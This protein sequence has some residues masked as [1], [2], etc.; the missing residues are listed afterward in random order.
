MVR[1]AASVHGHGARARLARVCTY[2]AVHVH[3]AHCPRRD[4]EGDSR[5]PAPLTEARRDQKNAGW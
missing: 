1:S 5:E 2:W 4:A 3:R